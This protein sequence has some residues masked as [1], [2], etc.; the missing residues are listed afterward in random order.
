MT[1][2]ATS[3]PKAEAKVQFE[4]HELKT[5]YN[6]PRAARPVAITLSGDAGSGKSSLLHV[7]GYHLQQMGLPVTCHDDL[8]SVIPDPV[9]TDMLRRFTANSSANPVYIRTE[10]SLHPGYITDA[11]VELI[12][13]SVAEL[14]TRLIAEGWPDERIN[15]RLSQLEALLR[16]RFTP[17]KE[18]HQAA[19][20]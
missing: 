14:A 20:G 1:T 16:Q 15:E 13:Q 3:T 12:D 19:N 18:D 6:G 8:G 5:A 11:Q 2:N 4:W 9:T 17:L 10:N 7:I